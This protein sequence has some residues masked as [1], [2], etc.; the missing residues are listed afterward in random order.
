MFRLGIA[1]ISRALAAGEFSSEELTTAYL[2][3]IKEKDKD[4]NAYIT[5]CEE[6]EK[7]RERK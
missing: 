2:A 6:Q 7:W 5:L 1:E 4:F 3:R